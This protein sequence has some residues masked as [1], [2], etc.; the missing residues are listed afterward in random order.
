MADQKFQKIGEGEDT[1]TGMIQNGLQREKGIFKKQ[2]NEQSVS[3]RWH[4]FRQRSIHVIRLPQGK[5]RK[6]EE[7]I[8]EEIMTK[9]F[10]SLI[11]T[12]N[13]QIEKQ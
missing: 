8:F 7:E 2:K 9:I 10:P 13:S 11:K 3:E 4:N 5:G 6:V 12:I 1:A